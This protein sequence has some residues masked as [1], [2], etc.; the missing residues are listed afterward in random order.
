MTKPYIEVNKQ[1]NSTFTRVSG[2]VIINDLT[3]SHLLQLVK[4]GSSDVWW[5][6]PISQLLP[7]SII[8]KSSLPGVSEDYEPGQ[9]ILDIWFDS[10]V[11]WLAALRLDYMNVFNKIT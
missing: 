6:L 7:Q 11:S 3:I 2:D 1:Y 4:N 10:G 9:D 8:D 5:E